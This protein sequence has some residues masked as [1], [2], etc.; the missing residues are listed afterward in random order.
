MIL[1]YQCLHIINS[2]NTVIPTSYLKAYLDLMSKN[3]GM[4]QI[5]KFKSTL[6]EAG[7]Y[8]L[9]WLTNGKN[10]EIASELSPSYNQL[11][12]LLFGIQQAVDIWI[13]NREKRIKFN[14]L[15]LKRLNNDSIP[16][17]RYHHSKL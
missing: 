10:I 8:A 6:E 1:N 5:V 14:T 4:D 11:R 17:Y 16:S 13:A 2:D 12:L 9:R 15:L 3:L 7:K